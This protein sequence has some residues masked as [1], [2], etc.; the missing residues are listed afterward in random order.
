[1]P[2]KLDPPA[3]IELIR[4]RIAAVHA[5]GEDPALTGIAQD[6]ASAMA[7]GQ[8]REQAYAPLRS[9]VDA[10]A[11]RYARVASVITTIADVDTLDGASILGGARPEEIG[12]GVGQ[13][14]H[15]ELGEGAIYVVVLLGTRRAGS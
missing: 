4:K 5:A 2:P 1:V 15:P 8:S 3:A 6:L 13:G 12:I 9:R 7:K 14:A 10:L 11:R